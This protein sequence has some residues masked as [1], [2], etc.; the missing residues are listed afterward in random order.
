MTSDELSTLILQ[1]LPEAEV[2]VRD[3][4]GDGNHFEA[5]VVS[6]KFHGKSRLERQR[7]V[8]EPLHSLL[9]GPLHALTFKTY[10]PEDWK[11]ETE[12]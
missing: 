6:A 3:L 4:T 2:Y 10:T 11:A 7:M 1:H 12:K 5:F 8:M 9:N